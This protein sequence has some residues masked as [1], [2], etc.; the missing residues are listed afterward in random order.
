MDLST[1]PAVSAVEEHGRK[2][3]SKKQRPCDLCRSRKTYCKIQESESRC[4]NCKKLDR[5]CT[6][7]LEPLKRTGQNRTITD[8]P[9]PTNPG[10]LPEDDIQMG[11][12]LGHGPAPD[13]QNGSNFD[14]E[15]FWG[16]PFDYGL[17]FDPGDVS[18]LVPM[19]RQSTNIATGKLLP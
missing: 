1:Q 16:R 7:V 14:E 6:F 10:T 5:R 2:Y 11:P 19:D 4:E 8:H 18:H 9:G 13:E 15:H 12:P 17:S 3:R